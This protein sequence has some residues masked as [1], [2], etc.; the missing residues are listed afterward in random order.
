M[1]NIWGK[2]DAGFYEF[3]TKCPC[4]VTTLCTIFHI[5]RISYQ[6]QLPAVTLKMDIY[7]S[8]PQ[9]LMDVVVRH[10]FLPAS[11]VGPRSQ[12]VTLLLFLLFLLS[13]SIKQAYWP[14]CSRVMACICSLVPTNFVLAFVV[15]VIKWHSKICEMKCVKKKEKNNMW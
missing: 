6:Q 2:N 14:C 11:H 13:L 12:Q 7:V 5:I 1:Q 10:M 3:F 4:Y 8:Y 9:F 15:H